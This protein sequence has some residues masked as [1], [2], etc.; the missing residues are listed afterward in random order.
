MKTYILRN[1]LVLIMVS[2]SACGFRLRGDVDIPQVLQTTML[3]GSFSQNGLGA[4]ITRR[5]TL[6]KEVTQVVDASKATALIVIGKNIFKKRVLTVDTNGKATAY[7]LDYYVSF[8]VLDNKNN[9]M[10]AIQEVRQTKEF[11]FDASNALATGDQESQIRKDM[12]DA[13]VNQ[14]FR[15]ISVALRPVNI[16]KSKIRQTTSSP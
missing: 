7:I 11:N 15:R 5:L 9:I 16:K 1:L 6:V 13:S 2:I 4:E 3:M 14:I 10:L 12:V 8:S